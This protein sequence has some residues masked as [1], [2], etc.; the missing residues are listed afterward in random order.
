MK[1][2]H[3]LCTFLITFQNYAMEH[4]HY[5]ESGNLGNPGNSESDALV[6]INDAPQYYTNLAKKL[7]AQPVF[8]GRVSATTYKVLPVK[9]W[10]DCRISTILTSNAKKFLGYGS[11]WRIQSFNNYKSDS[12]SDNNQQGLIL[13][14]KKKHRMCSSQDLEAMYATIIEALKNDWFISTLHKHPAI[15]HTKPEGDWVLFIKKQ[16]ITDEAEFIDHLASKFKLEDKISCDDQWLTQ[17]GGL[18]CRDTLYLW[19]HREALDEV[20]STFQFNILN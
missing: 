20:K 14:F 7:S 16:A 12:N 4:A 13:S 1:L 15:A 9:N 6:T 10:H 17:F 2:T 19:I 11:N 18:E 3:I 5:A 8:N